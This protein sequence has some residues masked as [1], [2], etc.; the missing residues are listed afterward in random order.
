V[1]QKRRRFF[2]H[3]NKPASRKA[4]RPVLTLHWLDKCHLVSRVVCKTE[5]ETHERKTQPCCVVRGWAKGVT[6][7]NGI[8]EVE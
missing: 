2:Y 5:T 4:G 7:N 1:S 8:A 3:Y 6:I